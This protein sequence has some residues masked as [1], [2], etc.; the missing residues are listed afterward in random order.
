MTTVLLVGVGAVGRRAARQLSETEGVE[1][2]LIAD[3]N[4]ARAREVA[5]AMGSAAEPVGWRPGDPVPSGV[6]V[7]AAAVEGSAEVAVARCAV[8]AGVPAALC[9]DG[10]GAVD[11]LLALDAAAARVGVAIAAGCGLAPGLADVLARHAGDALDQV[12]EVHVARSGSAGPAC[13]AALA[14]GGRSGTGV[15]RDG[16]WLLERA[17]GG[18][19][20]VWF[21]DPV[22]GRECRR[23]SSGQV[24]LLIDA[25]P[26][27]R[28]ASIRVAR[29]GSDSTGGRVSRRRRLDPDG[30]WGAVWVEVRGRRGRSEEVLV[31]GA[32]DRMTFAA[33]SVLAVAA[34][35]LAGLGEGQV[36]R[37]G[38]HGLAALVDP[39]PFLADLAQRGVRAAVVEGARL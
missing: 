7:L 4:T 16:S 33:G 11:G 20:L 30:E 24:P 17:G 5:A 31:Y 26:G 37:A 38:V 32:V 15:W 12:D 14:R 28:R 25:F 36:R 21:P 35:W 10:P 39:V 3:R 18:R 34:V 2:I 29:G 22:G 8:E 6:G 9:T 13:K 23:A 19:S 1:R 27:L